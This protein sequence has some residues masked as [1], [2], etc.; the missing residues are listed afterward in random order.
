MPAR[1]GRGAAVAAVLTATLLAAAP[2]ATAH[3][4]CEEHKTSPPIADGPSPSGGDIPEEFIERL[5]RLA[6]RLGLPENRD[7]GGGG[8]GGGGGP[9]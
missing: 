9:G 8:G 6:L 4:G 2:H 3:C 7:G 1:T 5:V